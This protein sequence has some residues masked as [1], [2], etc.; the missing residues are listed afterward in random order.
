MFVPKLTVWPLTR[1]IFEIWTNDT[2][3]VA[4]GRQHCSLPVYIYGNKPLIFGPTSYKNIDNKGRRANVLSNEE[5]LTQ[6]YKV[7]WKTIFFEI[8]LIMTIY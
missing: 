3:K 1:L 6:N 2:L 8:I 5:A 4:N 7:V